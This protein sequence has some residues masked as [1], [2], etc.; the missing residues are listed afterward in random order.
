MC[1][2]RRWSFESL[3]GKEVAGG[4]QEAEEQLHDPSCDLVEVSSF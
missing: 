2:S 3:K 4:E 1:G